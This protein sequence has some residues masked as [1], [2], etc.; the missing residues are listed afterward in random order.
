MLGARNEA[1]AKPTKHRGK[2]RIR[3]IDEKG[4]RQSAVF[5]DYR[6][7]Q[8]ELSRHQVE[9]EEVKRGIRNAP[10]PEKTFGDLCDYWLENRAPRKRSAKDD[11]SIIRRHL[12]PAFGDMRVRDVGVEDVDTYVTEKVDGEELSDKTVANH[13]TLLGTMMRTATAFK[14]PWLL[15]VPR[16]RKPKVTLFDRDYQLLRSDDEVRRFLVATT[17]EDENVGVLYTLAIYTGL[18]AGEMAG[19][20]WSDVDLER[21]LLTVQRSFDGPTKTDRVRYVPVLDPLLPVLRAWRLRHPGRHVF[22]NQAGTMLQPSARA[23]QEVLHRV[24]N[25]AGFQLIQRNGKER[26]Y[27]RFHDLR[28]TFASRW[29]MKGGD[30]FKLQ[31][32]LGHQSVQMTMRYAHLAPDAFRDDYARLGCA[33]VVSDADV[34]PLVSR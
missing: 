14:V 3:W 10:A 11:E 23:F 32:I 21:R 34:I 18:R 19:L 30:L 4:E 20:E 2:W 16:F 26:P 24:L 25:R 27:L 33:L 7:A 31:R 12:R 5:D 6:R 15:N 9:V 29:V 28:H 22:T 1:V 8:T 13:I 17:G